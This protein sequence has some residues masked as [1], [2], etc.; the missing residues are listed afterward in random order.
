MEPLWLC[1]AAGAQHRATPAPARQVKETSKSSLLQPR[2]KSDPEEKGFYSRTLQCKFMQMTVISPPYVCFAALLGKEQAAA[3]QRTGLEISDL[4]PN[5]QLKKPLEAE[6]GCQSV[7]L[8][9]GRVEFVSSRATNLLAALSWHF[10]ADPCALGCQEQNSLAR[11][12]SLTQ[13]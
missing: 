12:I 3:L 10:L 2:G 13:L 6:R 9:T 7:L 4:C 11:R 8:G 1:R 5:C